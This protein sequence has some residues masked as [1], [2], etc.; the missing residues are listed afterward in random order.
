MI[1]AGTV[2]TA[3]AR[4]EVTF[5][6][7]VPPVQ[8]RFRIDRAIAGAQSGEVLTIHEWSGAA[9]LQR[10][11]STGQRILIL[12]YPPSRLGLTS[13]VGGPLGQVFLDASGKYVST[14]EV[15]FR[16]E[17]YLRSREDSNQKNETGNVSIVQLE[18]AIRNAREE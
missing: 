13:P 15:R 3:E 14:A 16:N 8:V 17:T 6:G 10:P 4:T 9:S 12:L 2:L 7:A 5:S 11:M 1:F 18:R